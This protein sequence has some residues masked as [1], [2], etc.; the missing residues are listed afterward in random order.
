MGTLATAPGVLGAALT[1]YVTVADVMD[2]LGCRKNT[3][4]QTI[5]EVNEFAREND[6]FAYRQGKASKYVFADR[7]GIPMDVVDAVIEKNKERGRIGKKPQDR[8][9]KGGDEH[10][11]KDLAPDSRG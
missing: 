4:Y 5:R 3:A 1:T 9:Q 11:K 8:Q 2:L 10:K 6:K 7:F